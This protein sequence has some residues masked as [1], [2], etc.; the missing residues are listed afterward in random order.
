MGSDDFLDITP[1]RSVIGALLYV[2][3]TRLEIFFV[4]QKLNKFMQ[5]LLKSHWLTCKSIWRYL[6]ATN[7]YGL[8]FMAQRKME[9]IDYTN[10]DD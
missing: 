10:V 5:C 6:H 4:I 7:Y 8:Y 1:Y 2:T 9:L 3:I